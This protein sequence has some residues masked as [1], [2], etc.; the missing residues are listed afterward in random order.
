MSQ[1]TRPRRGTA[2]PPATRAAIDALRAED[3]SEITREQRNQILT[4]IAEQL[5][6]D[7]FSQLPPELEDGDE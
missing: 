5:G 7:L 6:D 4:Q 3:R 1:R 2:P